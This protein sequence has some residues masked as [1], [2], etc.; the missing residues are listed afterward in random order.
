MDEEEERRKEGRKKHV[1]GAWVVY[2]IDRRAAPLPVDASVSLTT[3]HIGVSGERKRE[4]EGKKKDN[5]EGTKSGDS[6]LI[7]DGSVTTS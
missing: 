1:S 6:S 4:G 7:I 3:R 2:D 5:V